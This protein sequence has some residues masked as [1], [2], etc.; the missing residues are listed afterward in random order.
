MV[1]GVLW[2][3]DGATEAYQGQDKFASATSAWKI[4]GVW[5]SFMAWGLSLTA[6]KA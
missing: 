4:T 1:P 5:G 3:W 2:G 6:F